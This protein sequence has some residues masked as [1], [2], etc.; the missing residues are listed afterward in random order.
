ME[1]NE[2]ETLMNPKH[3]AIGF[4]SRTMRDAGIQPIYS[5]TYLLT[6]K[7]VGRYEKTSPR[8]GSTSIVE[9]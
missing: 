5:P 3:R 9:A 8:I 2:P 1:V 7:S 4:S 6:M